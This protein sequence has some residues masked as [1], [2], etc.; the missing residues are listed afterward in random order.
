MT[1]Q[2]NSCSNRRQS[3]NIGLWS[4]VTGWNCAGE[5][6][7]AAGRDEA[8]WLEYGECFG[9][10]GSA[11]W[12]PCNFVCGALLTEYN[13]VISTVDEWV[14]FAQVMMIKNKGRVFK[15]RAVM[16]D[17][18]IRGGNIDWSRLVSRWFGRSTRSVD[19]SAIVRV[20]LKMSV[21]ERMGRGWPPITRWLS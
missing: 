3:G 7:A 20:V 9:N 10:L 21:D 17:I 2:E 15:D 11:S 18:I 4:A 1:G 6:C 5:L 12:R 8:K 13:I 19:E 14:K 16:L